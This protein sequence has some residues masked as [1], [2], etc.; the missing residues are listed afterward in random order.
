MGIPML[1]SMQ[2]FNITSYFNEDLKAL[3]FAL[4]DSAAALVKR[5]QRNSES[6]HNVHR[7]LKQCY[8]KN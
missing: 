3:I 5:L 2:E 6:P 7:W 4:K 8:Q 1:K